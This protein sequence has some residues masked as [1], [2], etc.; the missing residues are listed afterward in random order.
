MHTVL[1]NSGRSLHKVCYFSI[2]N[3]SHVMLFSQLIAHQSESQ[4]KIITNTYSGKCT[5]FF[6]VINPCTNTKLSYF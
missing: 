6:N 5:E 3:N 1:T 4:K 2:T